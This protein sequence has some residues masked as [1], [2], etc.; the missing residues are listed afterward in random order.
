[1]PYLEPLGARVVVQVVQEKKKEYAGGLIVAPESSR[2]PSY[3]GTVVA[4]GP[5]TVLPTGQI[6]PVAMSEGDLVLFAKYG[7]TDIELNGES[8][9]ILGERDVIAIIR[10]DDHAAR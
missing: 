4:V 9:L 2:E 10:E 6:T 7:G 8:F 3:K 5:G 1:M